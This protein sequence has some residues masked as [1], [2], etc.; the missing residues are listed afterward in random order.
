ME[1]PLKREIAVTPDL[2]HEARRFRTILRT[3]ERNL[4]LVFKG[5]GLS[6]DVDHGALAE[7]FARWRQRFDATKYLAE[8]NRH[9]FVIYAAGL[10]L[11]ELIEARPLKAI[12]LSAGPPVDANHPLSRW[13]EGYAYTSFCL[14]VASAILK[15]MGEDEPPQDGVA[16]DPAFWDSFRENVSDSPANAVAFF[17]LVCGTDPN[18][19]APDVAWMRRALS[20]KPALPTSDASKKLRSN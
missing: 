9:D 5:S 11:K 10:M 20:G 14:S 7:A 8:T 12:T 13:P 17:D 3:F 15:E 16:D 19:D 6:A 1:L 18:W 2:S 4:E